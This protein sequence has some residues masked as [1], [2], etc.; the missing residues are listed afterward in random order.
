M[1][2]SL[3]VK[4]GAVVLLAAA[5]FLKVKA[6]GATEP[7]YRELGAMV[8]RS[9]VERGF[10]VVRS[11][12]GFLPTVDARRAACSL[13]IA[14]ISPQGWQWDPIRRS[15]PAGWDAF[16]SYSGQRY[17]DQPRW[18]TTIGYYWTRFI[19]VV[20]LVRPQALVLGVITSPEC[21]PIDTDWVHALTD[22]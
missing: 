4:G 19:R 15:A 14:S 12:E 10:T 18:R 16:V 1:N 7:P 22:S 21:R 11:V 3:L 9:L 5:V 8:G 2:S 13:Q 17:D 20:G 6:E